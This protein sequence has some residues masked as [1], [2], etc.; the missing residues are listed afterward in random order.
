[1]LPTFWR[2]I[3]LSEVARIERGNE[4]TLGAAAERPTPLF[5]FGV[6]QYRFGTSGTPKRWRDRPRATAPPSTSTGRSSY[7]GCGRPA[8]RGCS[9]ARAGT[10]SPSGCR[11]RRARGAGAVPS[12]AVIAASSGWL[13]L[14]SCELS[15][16]VRS[17]VA[18][19]SSRLAASTS[20][21]GSSLPLPWPNCSARHRGPS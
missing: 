3:S 14:S 1:M 21:S 11:R 4:G 18:C 8:R 15:T 16:L 9:G 12:T 6:P 17:R 13:A 5:R 10:P 2:V 20:A 19:A 7:R